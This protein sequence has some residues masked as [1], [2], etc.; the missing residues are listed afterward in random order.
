MKKKKALGILTLL[1]VA[2]TA[3]ALARAGS[4]QQALPE[5]TISGTISATRVIAQNA[6]LT[7]NVTCTV[8]SAPCIQFG[9]PGLT[10]NLSGFTI[11]GQA[12]PASGCQG[13]RIG[14]SA[15]TVNE[16]G[17]FVADQTDE[18]IQGPG[19][20]QR[21]RGDG[22]YLLNSSRT[23]V[24][25]VTTSTNCQSGILI[26]NSADSRIEENVSVRNGNTAFP[27][28]GL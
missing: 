25:H 28:G 15:L 2:L 11:T 1:F 22:I 10:L 6:R 12:D 20:V 17:I 8:N 16:D 21:F 9:V 23:L 26:N 13:G 19:L 3:V 4:R 24:A 18:T 14:N 7:G 27:C 5:E